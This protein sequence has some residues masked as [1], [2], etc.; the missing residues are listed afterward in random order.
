MGTHRSTRVAT[1][2]LAACGVLSACRNQEASAK[3][4]PTFEKKTPIESLTLTDANIVAVLDAASEADS[5]LGAQAHLLLSSKAVKAYAQMMMRDHHQLR[6]RVIHL[7]T[8]QKITSEMPKDDPFAAAVGA[9]RSAVRHAR[10]GRRLDST[11]IANEI[12]IHSAIVNWVKNA[13]SEAHSTALVELIR[14]AE[15]ELRKHLDHAA[16][17]QHMLVR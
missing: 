1:M 17:M 8:R 16:A 15:P 10:Y 14:S 6:E 5:T 2:L 11:Y 4:A 13:E 7:A 3:S 9:E 12:E